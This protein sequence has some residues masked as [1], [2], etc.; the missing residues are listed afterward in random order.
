[1]KTLIYT[2][3]LGEQ[4][5]ECARNMVS[6]LRTYG[7]YGGDIMVY[8]DR[9]VEI[10]GA[11]VSRDTILHVLPHVFLA[12]AMFG[13]NLPGGYD[14]IL[15]LDADLAIINS[16]YPLLEWE[17]DISLPVEIVD[18]I[19]GARA[20]FSIPARPCIAGDKGW[21]AGTISF[22]SKVCQTFCHQWWDTMIEERA[23]EIPGGID[24]PVI[25]DLLRNYPR[26]D[27]KPFPKEWFFFFTDQSAPIT[28]ET[29]IVHPKGDKLAT[30][31]AALQMRSLWM[32]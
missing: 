11:S 20:W 31:R 23:W 6:S 18:G 19:E 14:R 25:N 17:C 27:F 1:M 22:S 10:H 15:Y 29:I 12:K 13:R 21:N 3:A 32:D 24:Q 2:V 9:D 26:W 8:C 5:I 28:K 30:Q 16:I 4:F 7:T